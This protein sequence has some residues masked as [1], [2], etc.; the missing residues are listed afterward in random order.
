MGWFDEQIKLRKERDEETFSNAMKEIAS[1]IEGKPIEGRTIEENFVEE[2]QGSFKNDGSETLTDAMQRIFSYL[3]VTCAKLPA[4]VTD[5]EEQLEYLC[6]P[7]GIMR[8]T[9]ALPS[10]WYH[11]AVGPMLGKKKDGGF[12]A[13]L[14][15]RLTGYC[16]VDEQTK[17]RVKLD[18]KTEKQLESE[19]ICFYKPFPQQK[20]TLASLMRYAY[21]SISLGT[22]FLFLL[23]TT[24]VTLVG[25]LSPK[26][27]HIIFSDVVTN[28]NLRLLI[29]VT[30]LSL[31]VSISALLFGVIKSL[32]L[33]R[34][35][36]QMG[37]YIEAACMN[38]MLSLPA[39]FFKAYSSGDL[40]HRMESVNKLCSTLLSTIFSTGFT[41]LF[42]LIYIVQIFQY[43]PTL[44]IPALMVIALTVGFSVYNSFYQMKR[45]KMMM[46]L[47]GEQNGMIYSMLTGI[48]KIKLSGSEKR[49][50][51]R[52]LRL[53]NKSAKLQYCPPA[54]CLFNGVISTGISLAGTIVMYYFAVQSGLSV[55]DYYAFNTAYGMV[56]G[57]FF[58][59]A[60]IAMT[61]ANI[62]PI[63][64][65]AKP[66]LDAQPEVAKG[67]Q[68]VTKLQGEIELNN[69]T[70][71]Y[72]DSMPPVLEDL[73]L[74]I[75]PGQYVAIV[76]KTGCGK[77]TLM[78]LLLGF[79]TPQKGA[80]YYDGKDLSTLD[81]KSLRR[82]IGSVMQ[83]GNLFRGD[84]YSNIVISAPQ[85]PVSAAWEA[86]E[87]ADIADDIR[88]MPMGMNTLVTENGGS[89]SGGQK[90]RLM[91]ARAV[92]PK[93]KILFFDEATSALDNI[94]QK[95]VSESLGS[96]KST[97]IV[98]AHRLST[99]RQCDRILVLDE[100][101]IAEDGTYDE[102]IAKKGQFAELVERQRVDA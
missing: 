16:Y 78:R 18:K 43:A 98:I 83:N 26:V 8:R 77:S 51:A 34:V 94:T 13:L 68:I 24:V 28:G 82:H 62:R 52:W 64:E 7:H 27:T 37:L 76:G 84:L 31:S 14:P 73:S 91:I 15:G 60:G 101:K 95:K 36:T 45:G 23:S 6:R 66:I 19:A 47:A 65:R 71:R 20:L 17:K 69:V 58:A 100:G 81:L 87:L 93:P 10:G 75:D 79:E 12:V 48:Q 61:V 97:R 44:V 53:Y 29:G 39:S 11:D 35:S 96:L 50:F 30:I 4:N 54:L 38:R 74:K 59:F 70:F 46:K 1:I 49:M 42:S 56:N 5:T 63:F 40:A 57:A 86:A 92:A 22:K 32:L 90:Q 21:D 25:M 3:H 88:A 9:V 102:L 99:I 89:I 55:A 2:N 80:I 67:R 72:T 85:L 33:D 41:S